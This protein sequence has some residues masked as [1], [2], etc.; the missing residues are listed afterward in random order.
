MSKRTLITQIKGR[1]LGVLGKLSK[2]Q[3]WVPGFRERE[4]VHS[5]DEYDAT[6]D[7]TAADAIAANNQG[8]VVLLGV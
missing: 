8:T 1:Y 5:K 2:R 3:E 6:Q 7:C 4:N